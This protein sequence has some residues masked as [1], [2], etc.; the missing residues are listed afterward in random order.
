MIISQ[1]HFLNADPIF[2]NSVEG[3]SRP[4]INVHDSVIKLYAVCIILNIKFK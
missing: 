3:I 1:P 2:I 4:D